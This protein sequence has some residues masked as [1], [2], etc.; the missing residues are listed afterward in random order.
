MKRENL[1]KATKLNIDLQALLQHNKNA[2]QVGNFRIML[3]S[4]S[5][6]LDETAKKEIQDAFQR[7]MERHIT[8]VNQQ[9]AELG[10]TD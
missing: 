6:E 7:C 5:P 9:L 3:G 4:V 1:N 10:I 2:E 8:S